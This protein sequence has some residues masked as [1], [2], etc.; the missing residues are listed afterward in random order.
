MPYALAIVK[1]KKKKKIN[2]FGF[3]QC[4]TLHQIQ[5]PLLL[6]SLWSAILEKSDQN[7]PKHT[8]KGKSHITLTSKT[9]NTRTFWATSLHASRTQRGETAASSS[10]SAPGPFADSA[11][12]SAARGSL[13]ERA[14]KSAKIGPEIWPGSED[15]LG[16]STFHPGFSDPR[17]SWALLAGLSPSPRT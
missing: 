13:Q 17:G 7:S 10:L 1:H 12:P 2:A 11:K 8:K 5:F 3:S 15:S 9:E 16:S 4:T 6:N 14:S